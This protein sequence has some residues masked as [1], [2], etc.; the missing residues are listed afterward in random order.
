M[1]VGNNY[2]DVNDQRVLFKQ[3]LG[4][5]VREYHEK[6]YIM[7]HCPFHEHEDNKPSFKVHN[8][9]YYC[10]GCGRKGYHWDFLKDYNN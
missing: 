6:E 4:A 7:Y 1:V 2:K 3:I 5:P 8:N 10:Y 9:G